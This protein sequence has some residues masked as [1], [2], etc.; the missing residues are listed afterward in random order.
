MGTLQ[1]QY[2]VMEERAEKWASKNDEL[3]E[4]L[5]L[6]TKV[7]EQKVRNK[8]ESGVWEAI[9][10]G[11]AVVCFS[12]LAEHARIHTYAHASYTYTRTYI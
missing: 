11:A 8:Y 12:F 4:R 10:K 6:V 1:K 3:S 9:A 2:D 7:K 5:K